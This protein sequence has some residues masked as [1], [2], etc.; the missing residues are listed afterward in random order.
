[1]NPAS[2]LW[3]ARVF[4]K[5][6]RINKQI[7]ETKTEILNATEEIQS[8]L[9]EKILRDLRTAFRHLRDGALSSVSDI[10]QYE[11]Q[12]ARQKFAEL[13]ELDPDDTTKGTSGEF[14]N[15]Y[16]IALGYLGN[17]HY[18][19][20]F[21]DKRMAAVQVY[22]CI[23]RFLEWND[24]MKVVE[25]FSIE[26]L[27]GFFSKNYLKEI[28]AAELS[29]DIAKQ[30]LKETEKESFQKKLRTLGIVSAGT[31]STVV[32]GQALWLS[33]PIL[34]GAGV[35][36]WLF[37]DKI[38]SAV[39]EEASQVAK[40]TFGRLKDMFVLPNIQEEKDSA[41]QLEKL[42]KDLKSAFEGECSELL[43]YLQSTDSSELMVLDFDSSASPI[44]N[45]IE[46]LVEKNSTVLST[47]SKV[48]LEEEKNNLTNAIQQGDTDLVGKSLVSIRA[49]L[50]NPANL[51]EL[52]EGYSELLESGSELLDNCNQL[53]ANLLDIGVLE[54]V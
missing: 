18:Y 44:V 7:L 53:I 47:S 9:D 4:S 17:F 3:T 41:A 23:N 11:F 33:L 1:M 51:T 15:R 26:S 42:L 8:K 6:A 2:A 35:A 25:T 52:V 43:T 38:P 12:T 16:L 20:L 10:Q 31:V 46:D 32:A 5:L 37:S 36:G 30:G 13:V 19:N 45:R 27:D 54:G 14:S 39:K 49:L 50:L 40:N 28:G 22:E 34:A 24:Y 29:L 21:G 48:T